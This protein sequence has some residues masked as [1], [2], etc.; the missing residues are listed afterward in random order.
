M[1]PI[2]YLVDDKTLR[3]F[4]AM[5]DEEN[6]GRIGYVDVDPQNPSKIIGYSENP[7]L[8]IGCDGAFDDGGVLPSCVIKKDGKL[9]MFYSAYQKMVKVPYSILS[10]LS[11][12]EDDGKTFTRVSEVPILERTDVDQFIRSAIFCLEDKGKYK[13]WYSSGTSWTHNKVKIVPKYNIRC[14]ESED[15]FNWSGC[16]PENSILLEGDEYGLTTP[17]VEKENGVYKMNYSIRSISKGYH[18]GYAESKDGVNYKRMDEQMDVYTSPTGWDSEMI[19]FGNTIKVN[20]KKY[21]F[22]CGNHYGMA[23]FGYAELIKE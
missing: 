19:C 8:D 9:Y 7:C 23:G 15:L 3:I 22:Y 5:C 21:L 2:P 4:L 17:Q 16:E 14:I 10:G 6:I 13:I 20:E 1:V 18:L 11:V 12:S